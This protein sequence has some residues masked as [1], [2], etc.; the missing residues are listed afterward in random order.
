LFRA[1]ALFIFSNAETLDR[2]VA[3]RTGDFIA[4]LRVGITVNKNW[5]VGFIVKNIS[6]RFYELR[7]GKAEPHRNFTMQLRYTF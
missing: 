7:P 6:N 1:A 5:K 4:D 3:N 2:Y